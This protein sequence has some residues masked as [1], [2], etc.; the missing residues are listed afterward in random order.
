MNLIN[1]L[2]TFAILISIVSC[3]NGEKTNFNFTNKS[4]KEE[5]K[6]QIFRYTSFSNQRFNEDTI[7][8]KTLNISHEAEEKL[9][10]GRYY[11]A[12]DNSLKSN[13]YIHF[14]INKSSSVKISYDGDFIIKGGKSNEYNI[15]MNRIQRIREDITANSFSNLKNL[16]SLYNAY[17][18]IL[19]D[20]R[21]TNSRIFEQMINEEE[22][23]L[24]YAIHPIISKKYA[25]KIGNFY[26]ENSNG[27][28]FLIRQAIDSLT[29]SGF[30]NSNDYKQFL[31]SSL[32]KI[33][34]VDMND[35][36]V[37]GK[38]FP[39]ITLLELDV[40][41]APHIKE[42]IDTSLYPFTQ[43]L[44]YHINN[45]DN[46]QYAEN[47][48]INLANHYK[49]DREL[50]I[51]YNQWLIEDFFESSYVQRGDA[52]RMINYHHLPVGSNSPDFT[53]FTVYNDTITLS[54]YKG[55]YLLLDFWGTWC[56]PCIKEIP[57]I[58][59][60]SM[61]ANKINLEILGIARDKQENLEE[62]LEHNELNYKT[63][64]SNEK[65]LKDFGVIKYPTK[66]LIG[67]SGEIIS[68]GFKLSD[69]ISIIEDTEKKRLEN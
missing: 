61:V 43:Y 58:N 33:E 69:V 68:K 54:D 1:R 56:A 23:Y 37:E 34:A 57:E 24:H 64:L 20:L 52:R 8:F 55:K 14:Y 7:P 65:V 29:L 46:K 13:Y 51:K 45:S 4:D 66:I 59:N 63:V 35:F 32:G 9:P 27:V 40:S 41:K 60:L 22:L 17:S 30:Y 50:S 10:Y 26:I 2:L 21:K 18:N 12:S 16:D 49:E 6:L 11:I 67:K 39:L 36:F 47:L 28:T 5:I 25:N 19:N 15:L 42:F 3:R 44:E 62:F 31:S 38:S 48:L 53:L